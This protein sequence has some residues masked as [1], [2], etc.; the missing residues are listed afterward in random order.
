MTMPTD[1]SPE[2]HEKRPGSADRPASHDDR[3]ESHEEIMWATHEALLK[4]GYA[5][6]GMRAIAAES[7]KSHSLLT[8]H[9][10]TKRN[11][12][13]AYL[14][15]L[16]D[17]LGDAVEA[18]DADRP[19]DR[20]EELLDY[21]T[22]G[23]EVYPE[24]LQRAFLEFQLLALRDEAFRETLADH[25]RDNFEL[26]ADVVADGVERGAFREDLDPD[27]LARLILSAVLGASEREI[28]EGIEGL[29]DGVR[30][31]LRA[32]LYP[33]ILSDDAAVPD[34]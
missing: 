34:G 6:L 20:L 32:E 19:L 2:G 31:T 3:P 1:D 18:S 7:T 4:H 9:Y 5:D 26:V 22:V 27:A 16:V 14:D 17:L 8:Y 30:E 10:D 11:L 28:A 15:F 25:D 12:V 29:A 24:S 23:T 21:F 33:A 13:G